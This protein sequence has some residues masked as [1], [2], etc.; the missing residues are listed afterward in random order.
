[1]NFLFKIILIFIPYFIRR[2]LLNYLYN[3]NLEAGSYI[4]F[5]YIYP[6]I[7]IMKKGS[8]IG[9]FNTAIHLSKITLEANSKIGR[10]NWIT[11]YP[12]NNKKHFSHL[13]NRKSE[14]F[15]GKESAITK[16]HHIDCTDKI[17]IGDYS[18]I[19]GY[20]SQLITHQI[21]IIENRQTCNP[22]VIGSYTYVG[23]NV[24]I[25]GGSKLPSYSILGAKSLL[26]KEFIEEYTLYGGTPAKKIKNIP[27]HSKYFKRTKGFVE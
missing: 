12:M 27:E 14:L 20:H 9:H 19:G 13:T 23:T 4:G 7:L 8:Y 3:Y 26:K 6:E 11:G 22:I 18:I 10:F 15:I 17:S 2:Y 21:D 1:M 24:V 5:S 16:N 25:L